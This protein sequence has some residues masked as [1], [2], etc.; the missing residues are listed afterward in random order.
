MVYALI[1]EGVFGK[2]PGDRQSDFDAVY[3]FEETFARPYEP[4]AAS[5]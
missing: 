3:D 2:N 1:G 5:A 4:P